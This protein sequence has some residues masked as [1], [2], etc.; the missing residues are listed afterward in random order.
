MSKKFETEIVKYRQYFILFHKCNETKLILN[1]YFI[2]EN[3]SSVIQCQVFLFEK[4][5]IKSH[6][7]PLDFLVFRSF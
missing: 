7:L 2:T 5:R 6:L 1:S 3:I 4:Q